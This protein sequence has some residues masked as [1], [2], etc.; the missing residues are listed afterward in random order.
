MCHLDMSTICNAT[1]SHCVCTFGTDFGSTTYFLTG[2]EAPVSWFALVA[3]AVASLA[4]CKQI[5]V[6]H[7]FVQSM[8]LNI[9]MNMILASLVSGFRPFAYALLDDQ[10]TCQMERHFSGYQLQ[11]EIRVR[12]IPHP[13]LLPICW[14]QL[15]L[16]LQRTVWKLLTRGLTF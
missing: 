16:R 15:D 7:F 3:N 4:R 9:D 11:C 1:P 5:S 2:Q 8:S 12:S 10:Q 14:M 6:L 13:I